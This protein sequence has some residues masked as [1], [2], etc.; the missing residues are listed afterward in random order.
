MR[1]CISNQ[2]TIFRSLN[3]KLGFWNGLK[4]RLSRI[5]KRPTVK[6]NIHGTDMIICPNTPDLNVAMESLGSEFEPIRAFLPHNFEGVI[7]DAGGYIGSAAIKLSYM[8]PARRFAA[9]RQQ[10]RTFIFYNRMWFEITI[11]IQ[12]RQRWLRAPVLL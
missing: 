9:S 2:L 12:L 3:R 5:I 10:N 4:Y 6:I 7:I 1:T 8:Y 11:L